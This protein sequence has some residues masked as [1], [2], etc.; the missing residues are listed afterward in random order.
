MLSFL[1]SYILG[2]AILLSYIIYI[3]WKDKKIP[4]S[5]SA[6]VYSLDKKN[7]WIYTIVILLAAFLIAPYLFEITSAI[8]IEIVAFFTMVGILGVG[9][10]CLCNINGF[11][12]PS[13]IISIMSIY[14]VFMASIY[15][16]YTIY[17]KRKMEY[18]VWRNGYDDCITNLWNK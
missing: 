10:L 13:N 4:Q 15:Y 11:F 7:K 12:K 9:A 5:I 16:L 17:G 6:T 1:I 3:I 18:D 8:G 14:N 2:F